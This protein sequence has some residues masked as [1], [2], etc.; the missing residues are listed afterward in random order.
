MNNRRLEEE[1]KNTLEDLKLSMENNTVVTGKT[2]KHD[3][4]LFNDIFHYLII[5]YNCQFVLT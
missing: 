2:L 5:I 1:E 3:Y 4:L